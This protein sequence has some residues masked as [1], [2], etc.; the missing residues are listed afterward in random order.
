[1]RLAA[2]GKIL[3]FILP[4]GTIIALAYL[5]YRGEQGDLQTHSSTSH[6]PDPS[7]SQQEHSPPMIPQVTEPTEEASFLAAEKALLEGSEDARELL[8]TLFGRLADPATP[9]RTKRLLAVL[10]GRAGG[11]DA[12]LRLSTIPSASGDAQLTLACL[13]AL[14]LRP[15]SRDG[16]NPEMEKHLFRVVSQGY[17]AD[18]IEPQMLEYYAPW[19]LNGDG[20][21]LRPGK[22]RTPLE[23]DKLCDEL[24]PL[25]ADLANNLLLAMANL[26]EPSQRLILLGFLDPQDEANFRTLMAFVT[27]P[28]DPLA[29]ELTMFLSRRRDEQA[30]RVLLS[31]LEK[32]AD[33]RSS[34]SL[35]TAIK[36]CGG[37]PA[38]Q[39]WAVQELSSQVQDYRFTAIQIL[40]QAG[41]SS[42]WA[43]LTLHF[44]NADAEEKKRILRLVDSQDSDTRMICETLI[45][46]AIRDTDEGVR[47]TAMIAIRRIH[48]AAARPIFEKLSTTDPSEEVRKS[49]A[50]YLD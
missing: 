5:R 6:P 31:A 3:A 11:A 8:N 32:G 27:A 47:I 42:A 30:A 43:R 20:S 1:M 18:G 13:F 29:A 4:V 14:S 44:D 46:K 22:G 17:M 37:V 21:R 41:G 25:P 40:G 23:R 2:V 12:R 16:T 7:P 45:E 39:A 49:A 48:G 10:L 19:F 15:L 36:Q 24:Q 38:I 34:P 28:D 9:A 50:G 26:S 33:E 35:L